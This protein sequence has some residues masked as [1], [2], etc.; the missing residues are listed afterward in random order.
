[1]IQ[2]GIN[3][4]DNFTNIKGMKLLH[5]VYT[6]LVEVQ[7]WNLA[8]REIYFLICI[9]LNSLL[10]STFHNKSPVTI[11]TAPARPLQTGFEQVLSRF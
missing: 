7:C 3:L 8:L 9:M 2:L 1:V 4:W 11:E 10:R 6:P 5:I